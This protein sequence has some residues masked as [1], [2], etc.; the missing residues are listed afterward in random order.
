MYIY[1]SYHTFNGRIVLTYILYNESH[2]YGRI[3]TWR[4]RGVRT[5]MTVNSESHS[6]D[7]WTSWYFTNHQP[8]AYRCQPL[9]YPNH[10]GDMF[11]RHK[12]ILIFTSNNAQNLSTLELISC[13]YV[14]L[15]KSNTHATETAS[16]GKDFYLHLHVP[17]LPTPE[18]VLPVGH[19]PHSKSPSPW[20]LPWLQAGFK[21]MYW[22]QNDSNQPLS[23]LTV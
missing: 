6:I 15:V 1:P 17:G 4:F 8:L 14:M 2:Q 11:S 20:M 23:K 5:H 19:T 22:D 9:Q 10:S 3:K 18:N 12:F 21:S 7:L 13:I 16:I